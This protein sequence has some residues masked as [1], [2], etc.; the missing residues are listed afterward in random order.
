MVKIF[1]LWKWKRFLSENLLI[2][3]VA[4]APVPDE[5]LGDEV[6]ACIVLKAGEANLKAAQSI[7]EHSYNSLAYYKTPGYIA[8]L[9][10]LPLTMSNK[11]QR[12]ELKVICRQLVEQGDCYDLRDMKKRQKLESKV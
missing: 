8:F 3:Q 7:F 11:P 1:P 6:M 5:L 9:D 10:Q 2:D 4:V 12:G